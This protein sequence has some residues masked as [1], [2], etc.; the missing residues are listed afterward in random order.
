MARCNGFVH[1]CRDFSWMNCSGVT[2]RV[3][4]VANV[5]RKPVR[6]V[7]N[8]GR[9]LTSKHLRRL[10]LMLSYCQFSC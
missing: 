10:F 8:R 4:P 1:L 9:E 2:V 5:M 6:Q 7:L 3:E